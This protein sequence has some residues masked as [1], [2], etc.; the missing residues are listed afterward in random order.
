MQD[1]PNRQ[2]AVLQ[3]NIGEGKSSVILPMVA[4]SVADGSRLARVFVAKP[5]W[6]Q[7]DEI[8]ISKLGGLV[9]R[10]IW[11]LPFSRTVKLGQIEAD[12]IH[13]ICTDCRDGRG[14]LL[15]Q[16]E[17]VLSLQLMA[18][19]KSTED[20]KKKGQDPGHSLLRALSLLERN[21]QDIIDESD[22]AFSPKFELIFTSGKQG[23]IEFSPRRWDL[24]HQVLGMVPKL[25]QEV[26]RKMPDAI[27]VDENYGNRFPRMRLLT[28]EAGV[29]LS[30][31]IADSVCRVSINGFAITRQTGTVKE[32]ILRYLTEFE[33][34]S[35]VVQRVD[36]VLR[37]E[38][39]RYALLLLRG[40][41]A[42][43]VLAFA[44]DQKRWTVNFGLEKL[45]RPA[46][47]LA[48]PYRDRDMPSPRSDFS[49]PDLLIVLTSL[50]YYYGGLSDEDLALCLKHVARADQGKDEYV[51]WAAGDAKLAAAL[52][53]LEG[54]NL[55]DKTSAREVFS[56]LRYSKKAIDYFLSRIVLPKEMREFPKLSASGWDIGRRKSHPTAGF[57][58]T[59]DTQIFLPIDMK[60]IHLPDQAHTDAMVLNN[61][62][63][64]GNEVVLLSELGHTGPCVG[65]QLLDV[66]VGMRPDVKVI[67]DV[68]AQILEMTN[69]QIAR[70]WL[71]MTEGRGQTEA[72]V[73]CDE[74]D[75]FLV[76]DRQ[77]HVEPL[78]TS[79]FARQ[80]DLCLVFMDQA[81]CFGTDLRL[82]ASSRAAVTLGAH[83]C[84]DKLAQVRM[85]MRKLGAGQTVV[86]CVP[87]VERCIRRGQP[88]QG[89]GAIE[90]CDIA[91]WA[92]SETWR[93]WQRHIG[94]WANQG[95]LHERQKTYWDEA[96]REECFTMSQNLER[97]F[98]EPEAQTLESRYRPEF[99]QPASI[100][101]VPGDRRSL[102]EI[103]QRCLELV[104]VG[105]S[106]ASLQEQ[107]ERELAPE[108]E[109]EQ[110]AQLQVPE[111][112]EP[113]THKLE[114]KV[115]EFVKDGQ[116][117]P[118]NSGFMWAFEALRYTT[119]G[120]LF[121]VAKFPSQ[122]RCNHDFARTL[123]GDEP[124]GDAYQRGVQWVLTSHEAGR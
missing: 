120:R 89:S 56:T 55:S 9:G 42:G 80:L 118:S 84:K 94:L 11:H 31:L 4:A 108:L 105:I 112:A 86:Y 5:Q 119:A 124:A 92:I 32:A 54:L 30:R 97:R 122:L 45:R 83:L 63:A 79:P 74:D 117:P 47:R 44:F 21:C 49:H 14:I 33:V 46:T 81:R 103:D 39:T 78:K 13:R 102:A 72:A 2:N 77:G 27:E 57:S 52:G 48:V 59:K 88:R 95:R 41:L 53:T 75:E 69:Q 116:V 28:E 85:R 73:F 121:D 66:V 24:V 38:S 62:V 16:P 68:G 82:P 26:K 90:P 3:L 115:K 36:G 61:M 43:R 104:H 99:V 60:Q 64:P 71:D 40:L 106:T 51:D 19:L 18:I 107:Q 98:L 8:L 35:S 6:R 123:K 109:L 96:R 25:A 93:D 87:H 50:C 29:E 67:L 7:M 34:D 17:H 22:E 15:I 111:D 100:A 20:V 37:V 101:D 10:R 1:P 114:E 12:A 76:L 58:G 110:E 113:A 65:G 91:D 23:P 70:T